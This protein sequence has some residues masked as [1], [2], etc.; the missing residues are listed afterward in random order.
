[1]KYGVEVIDNSDNPGLF[2]E[3]DNGEIIAR[4]V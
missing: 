3:K 1:M 4:R 2:L